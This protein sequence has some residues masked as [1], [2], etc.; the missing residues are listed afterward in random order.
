MKKAFLTLFFLH[1]A[2]YIAKA[3]YNNWAVGFQ[4]VEPSGVNLRKYFGENKALDI[5]AGTYG[6]FYGRD[7]AYR[8]GFYQ[9]AGWSVRA[10]YLWHTALFKSEQFRG[11][12]GFGGQVN[13]RRYYFDSR[14]TPGVK[15][16]TNTI[17]LGGVGHAGAEYF[18]NN[19]PL[20]VFLEVGIYA[21]VVPAP[22]F[23][24]PQG[25]IGVRFNF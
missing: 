12:Y 4:L 10:T 14:N 13:S 17:S 5:S 1:F 25:G 9:N 22:L 18:V 15:E 8:K 7:R 23:L 20:S 11:Y 16:Y 24:H 21:E 6:L 2:L 19:S 3:Q